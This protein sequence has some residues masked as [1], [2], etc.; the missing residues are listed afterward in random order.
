MTNIIQNNLGLFSRKRVSQEQLSRIEEEL[1]KPT[2]AEHREDNSSPEITSDWIY[3]PS[4]KM[5]FSTQ[6]TLQGKSWYEAHKT[7][8]SEG[9]VMPTP[10]QTFEL[11]FYLKKNLAVSDTYK[12]VYDSI[13]RTTIAGSSHAEW[14]N[15]FFRPS[16]KGKKLM[17]I[18]RIVSFDSASS[19]FEFNHS[20]DSGVCTDSLPEI[21]DLANITPDGMGK[22][23]N[24]GGKYVQGETM[25][26]T[27]P[28]AAHVMALQANS[29]YVG[30]TCSVDPIIEDESLGVRSARRFMK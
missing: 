8:L 16:E 19:E 4:I 21:C 29:T 11:I 9:L 14:Q 5:E 27:K 17:Y 22:S 1:L 13:L 24:Y 20:D 10:R 3:V 6:I 26:F 30:M 28:L 12:Q 25:F 18:D 15:A 23:A 7:L 2:D